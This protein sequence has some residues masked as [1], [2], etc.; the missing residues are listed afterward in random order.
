MARIPPIT[1]SLGQLHRQKLKAL[2]TKLLAKYNI[3]STSFAVQ[4]ALIGF[5][6][7][8][9]DDLVTRNLRLDKRRLK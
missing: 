4:I 2:Q 5:E 8:D 1:V 3:C 6:R 9:I 7:D